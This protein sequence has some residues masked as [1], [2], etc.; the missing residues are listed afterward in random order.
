MAVGAA[1]APL[2]AALGPAPWCNLVQSWLRHGRPPH[3]WHQDG[4]LRHHFLAHAGQPA[5]ADA[6]LQMQTLW[7]A[8]TPCGEDAPSLQWVDAASALALEPGRSHGTK[9]CL[10]RYGEARR[11]NTPCCSP[12]TPC[13]STVCA[14][15][16]LTSRPR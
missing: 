7:I 1:A 9:R 14:C 6:A 8:L 4:A 15:T 10:L 13:S 12:Q 5:P 11:C 16:A 3:S 2:V